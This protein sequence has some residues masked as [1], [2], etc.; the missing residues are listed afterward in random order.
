[1]IGRLWPEVTAHRP[2]VEETSAYS[3]SDEGDASTSGGS[4]TGVRG[5]GRGGGSD[6]GNDDHGDHGGGDADE[7]ESE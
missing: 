5:G 4:H 3:D 6:E 2:T 7:G 1:M